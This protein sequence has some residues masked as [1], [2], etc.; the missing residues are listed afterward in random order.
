[1]SFD[2][3]FCFPRG[4]QHI[5]HGFRFLNTYLS[6][7]PMI[8]HN[9]IILTDPGYETEAEEFFSLL[10]N[11]RAVGTPDHAR[12]LSRYEAWSKQT[13]A[14]CMMMLGG[15]TYCRRDGWG[16]RAYTAFQRLGPQNLY[17]ACGHTGQGPVH[18]HIRTT[19][20]WASPALLRRYP[21][22]PQNAGGRYEAE[23]GQ[24][25]ISG[26]VL[27]NGGQCWVINFGSEHTLENANDDPQGY[28]RGSQRDLIIG[29]RLT[30][31]PY[32]PFA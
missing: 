10:P 13:N 7:P 30:C 28:A 1:M 29:D 2:I 6:F 15:S 23:H 18:K 12:D 8:E 22:W 21:A 17:G 14:D 4:D 24:S 5:E 26:W 11:V 16:L 27:R 25:C 32:Q 19:G 9:S 20:F 31:P 3:C